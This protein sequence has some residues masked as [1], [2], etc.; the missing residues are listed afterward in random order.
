MCTMTNYKV[1]NEI[2]TFDIF[3]K[4]LVKCYPHAVDDQ[5]YPVL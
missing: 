3:F 5:M 4:V 1:S 2:D